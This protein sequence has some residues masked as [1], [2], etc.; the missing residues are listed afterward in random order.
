MRWLLSVGL[1]LL[2]ARNSTLDQA[3][4]GYD[5]GTTYFA[6]SLQLSAD[7]RHLLAVATDLWSTCRGFRLIMYTRATLARDELLHPFLHVACTECLSTGCVWSHV[8]FIDMADL[9]EIENL[10]RFGRAF[11]Q[12]TSTNWES[13]QRPGKPSD[14]R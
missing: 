7:V 14:R 13:Y 11:L 2:S 12:P 6:V 1:A 3:L 4:L 9:A 10:A 8:L 5:S